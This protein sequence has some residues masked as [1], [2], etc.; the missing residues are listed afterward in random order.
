MNKTILVLGA[1]A[2]MRNVLLETPEL[3][4]FRMQF[5]EL[6]EPLDQVLSASRERV[7]LVLVDVSRLPLWSATAQVGI[8]GIKGLWPASQVILVS[9]WADEELWIEAIRQGAFDVLA[10]PLDSREFR[11]VVGNAIQKCHPGLPA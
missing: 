6:S 4:G 9:R 3:H 10:K 5:C 8:Q 7:V 1:D 11:R 2:E